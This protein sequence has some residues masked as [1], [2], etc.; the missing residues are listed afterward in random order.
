MFTGRVD[1]RVSRQIYWPPSRITLVK[2][3]VMS[4]QSELD[5]L[6]ADVSRLAEERSCL[7]SDLTLLQRTCAGCRQCASRSADCRLS[8]VRS[9]IH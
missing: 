8:V 6:R 5:S 1:C 4:M 7:L 3:L 2:L 9:L